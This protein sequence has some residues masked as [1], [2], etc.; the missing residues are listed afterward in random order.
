MHYI[1]CVKCLFDGPLDVDEALVLAT[2]EGEGEVAL[3][4]DEGA[5]D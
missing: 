5:V 2:A 4:E 3:F 1:W